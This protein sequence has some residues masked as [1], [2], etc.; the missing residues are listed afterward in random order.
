M[1]ARPFRRGVAEFGCGQCLPCRINKRRVWTTRLVLETLAHQSSIFVTLT[2]NDENLPSDGSVNPKALQ[3]FLKRLRERLAPSRFRFYGAGEYGDRTS[4]AHYHVC[5]FGVACRYGVTAEHNCQCEVAEKWG[6]GHVHVGTVTPDSAAYCVEY[7]CKGLTK[8]GAAGLGGRHPEFARM[9]RR[10][11]IG[12][13]AA[14]VIA[15]G[16][17]KRRISWNDVPQVLRFSDRLVPLGRYLRGRI[18]D[19]SGACVY[20][21][22]YRFEPPDIHEATRMLERAAELESLGA[23]ALE[24]KRRL[25]EQSVVARHKIARWKKGKF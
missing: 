24:E 8:E 13:Y 5:L 16:L 17:R 1:C 9:S 10:P 25:N 7:T 3:A 20:K 22:R 2:Y 23:G 12:A 15:D 21:R 6:Q 14:E 4:R 11:G 19:Q 18:R